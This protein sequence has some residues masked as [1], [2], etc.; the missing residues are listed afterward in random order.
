M[1]AWLQERAGPAGRRS[2][3][4][5]EL[6]SIG[7]VG[8]ASD[9]WAARDRLVNL[10]EQRNVEVPPPLRLG[11]RVL[12]DAPVVTVLVGVR[13]FG[14]CIA[15]LTAPFRGCGSEGLLRSASCA[16]LFGC[17]G[18]GWPG[19]SDGAHWLSQ[20]LLLRRNWIIP[21]INNVEFQRVGN[22][23]V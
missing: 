9:T 7:E 10:C 5:A 19:D 6:S 18:S 13:C 11:W 1:D 22:G 14:W 17:G 20:S 12:V 4:R 8:G 16:V 23:S 21:V 3:L 15:L 2:G